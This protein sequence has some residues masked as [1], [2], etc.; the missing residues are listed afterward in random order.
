MEAAAAVLADLYRSDWGR[1]VATL[2]SLLGDFDLAE[3]AAQDAFAAAADHWPRDGVPEFPRAWIVQAARHKAID[4]IRRSRRFQELAGEYAALQSTL[5]E[6]SDERT[7]IGDDRLRLIFTCCH[8]ALALDAQVALTLRTLCG[9]DTDAIARAFLVPSAT[10]AQRLVRAKRKIRDA[11]IPYVEPDAADL[12]QRLDAVLTVIYLVFT[13]GYAATS[14]DPAVRAGLCAEAIRLARVLRQLMQPPPPE[15]TGLLALMLL[16]DSRRATRFDAAGEIVLLEDQDR[17]CWDRAQID[18]ALPLVD[19]ALRGGPGPFALQAAI[20]ALHGQAARAA[21]TDWRQIVRL[22]D[23]LLEIQPS[24][25]V[26][27]NRAVAIGMVDGP[28]PALQIVD[29]LAPALDRYHLLHAVR[30]DLQRRLDSRR[31]A[32]ASYARALALADSEA[33]RRFL[34]RRAAECDSEGPTP[35]AR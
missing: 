25:V 31:E 15:A 20:A 11:K 24:P 30:G 27:L 18:E 32:A 33:E 19:A 26:A 16:H 12:P 4:R 23:V 10:M 9:L 17:A 34:R 21:D 1:I 3:E 28:G 7:E 5:S 29:R 8:P 22:Y 35:T 6:S 2:I 13:E 14:A